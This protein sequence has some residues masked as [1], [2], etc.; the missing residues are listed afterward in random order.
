MK[1]SPFLS[2]ILSELEKTLGQAVSIKNISPEFG[3]NINESYKVETEQGVFFLKRN[4]AVDLPHLF[5][6]EAQ[7]LQLLRNVSTFKVPGVV[8]C[9]QYKNISYL[10]LDYIEKGL[11]KP[12]FWQQFGQALAKLHQHSNTQFGLDHNNYIGSLPQIN[13]PKENWPDFFTSERLVPLV[14]AA[15][16]KGKID[17]NTVKAFEKLCFKLP[18]IFPVE[19]PALLHGDLWSGN[20]L[21]TINSEPCV[22]D[23]AVYYGHR[24]MDIAMMQLFGGFH[25]DCL[26]AYQEIYPLESGWKQRV[27]ICNLYPLLVHTMLFGGSY[28]KQ[29]KNIVIPF[30]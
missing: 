12:F 10:L 20:Y 7:G 6:R 9:G 29:V 18:E 27:D 3:G 1:A 8:L 5:D 4:E 14:S 13:T 21:C 19:A 28:A 26:K 30:A 11:P 15:H 17:L 22:F 25:S 2:Y 16:E 23:P 24:E